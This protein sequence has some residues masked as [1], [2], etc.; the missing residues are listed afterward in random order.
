MA[1]LATIFRQVAR[2]GR[3]WGLTPIIRDGKVKVCEMVATI[4][5]RSADSPVVVVKVPRVVCSL[6]GDSPLD[7]FAAVLRSRAR[8]HQH[9]VMAMWNQRLAR[10]R[11]DGERAL[12]DRRRD[13]REKFERLIIRRQV[14][15]LPSG[16]G[17]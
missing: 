6:D 17:G 5:Q 8:R 3:K 13:F 14:M 7:A 2:E 10:E 12:A 1:S 16:T 4:T 9:D 15:S 11:A